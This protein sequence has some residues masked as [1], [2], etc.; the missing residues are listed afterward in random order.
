M[1]FITYQ[2]VQAND[3]FQVTSTCDFPLDN[4]FV[5]NCSDY[6]YIND[7]RYEFN[8]RFCYFAVHVL[9][10]KRLIVSSFAL[11]QEEELSKL[12]N[13]CFLE[14]WDEWPYGNIHNV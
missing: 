14:F 5:R 4:P 8:Q 7:N 13:K 1:N 2:H 10:K 6:N 9:T 11:H 12:K 3:M